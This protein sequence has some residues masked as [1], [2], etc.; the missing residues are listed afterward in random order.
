MAFSEDLDIYFLERNVPSTIDGTDLEKGLLDRQ[1][2]ESSAGDVS[3]SGYRPVLTC[4][5][6]DIPV[7]SGR[8]STVIVNSVTYEWSFEKPD[9][10]VSGLSEIVLSE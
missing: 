5:T 6:V 9:G 10:L 3:I 1:Y 8:G 2:V 7:G 4:K